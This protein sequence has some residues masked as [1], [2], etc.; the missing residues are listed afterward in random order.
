MNKINLK[1]VHSGSA[2]VDSS[3]SGRAVS[4]A[5]SKLYFIL[6]GEFYMISPDGEKTVLKSGNAYLVPS[7]YSYTFGCENRMSHIYFHIILCGVDGL[8]MLGAIEGP[9]SEPFGVI[10]D[11]VLVYSDFVSSLGTEG[12]IISTLH[13][14]LKKNK[15]SIDAASYSKEV[16]SAMEYIKKN[17]SVKT[18]IKEISANA[19]IAPS[20]LTRSFKRETGMTIGEYTDSLIFAEAQRLLAY[21]RLSVR[22]ISERFGFCD[23]FYFS[24]R[25]CEK[26]GI[27]P[28]KYRSLNVDI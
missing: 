18:G 1:L 4:P 11:G 3:W 7:G 2:L 5:D 19:F 15:I 16:K 26:Y 14:M 12:F 20:T 10:P 21:S 27:T 24:R 13:S 6:D 23:Q 25:F 28:S 22:E 9:I 17:L 8:D